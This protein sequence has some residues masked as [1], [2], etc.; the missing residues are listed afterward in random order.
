M[1]DEFSD[2]FIRYTSDDQSKDLDPVTEL[3]I[4]IAGVMLS[5]GNKLAT[6]L[7]NLN[8]VGYDLSVEELEDFI[9]SSEYLFMTTM[10]NENEVFFP[11]YRT[12]DMW[13]PVFPR[14]VRC[15]KCDKI[16]E[17]GD[18]VSMDVCEKCVQKQKML[19]GLH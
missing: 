15:K 2:S 12:D 7:N 8:E 3:E 9:E 13:R 1:R 14:K 4:D 5:Q 19:S 6:I 18:T 16:M 10:F 17:V 11:R